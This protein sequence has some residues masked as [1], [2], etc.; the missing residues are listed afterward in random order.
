MSNLSKLRAGRS[1]SL[2]YP[3]SRFPDKT[4]YLDMSLSSVCVVSSSRQ[5]RC[6]ECGQRPSHSDRSGEIVSSHQARGCDTVA[7][8][9]VV[10]KLHLILLPTKTFNNAKF[11]VQISAVQWKS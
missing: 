9:L 8:A 10:S 5:P 2:V 11:K 3:D 4:K 6:L 1:S 7:S